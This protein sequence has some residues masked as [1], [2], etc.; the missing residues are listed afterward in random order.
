MLA[1]APCTLTF[2]TNTL[3]VHVVVSPSATCVGGAGINTALALA[4][5]QL[6]VCR[7]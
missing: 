2:D 1:F 7:W 3:L 4:L 5:E 6:A